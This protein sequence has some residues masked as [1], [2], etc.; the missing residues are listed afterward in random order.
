MN[1]IYKDPFYVIGYLVTL[2]LIS[3]KLTFFILVLPISG[4][5]ISKISSG[6]KHGSKEGQENLGSIYRNRKKHYW[7]KN[8]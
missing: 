4:L 7:F 2:F 6:L 5:I 8:N 1:A 3:T